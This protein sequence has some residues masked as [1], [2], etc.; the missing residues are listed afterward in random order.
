MRER[1]AMCQSLKNPAIGGKDKDV[2]DEDHLAYGKALL[3]VD[4]DRQNF[5]SICAAA[6]AD[7]QPSAGAQHGAANHDRL[8]RIGCKR[9]EASKY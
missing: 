6:I 4:Q 3:A 5:G 2:D 1:S 7:D 8:E 9:G